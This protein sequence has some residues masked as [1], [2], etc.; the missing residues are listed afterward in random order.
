MKRNEP[1]FEYW[2][3]TEYDRVLE[4]ME[5]SKDGLTSD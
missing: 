1:E 3:A 4:E 2:H 5:C